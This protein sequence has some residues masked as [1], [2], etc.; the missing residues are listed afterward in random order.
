MGLS[1]LLSGPCAPIVTLKTSKGLSSSYHSHPCRYSTP[2]TNRRPEMVKKPELPKD[3]AKTCYLRIS[4]QP[5]SNNERILLFFWSSKARNVITRVRLGRFWF[6]RFR[7]F[8]KAQN[9]TC[10]Q[11]DSSV[12]SIEEPWLFTRQ[13]LAFMAQAMSTMKFQENSI[14]EY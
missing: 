6:C 13:V 12:P 2:A 14:A 8:E 11:V 9:A 10:G 1:S 4:R 3:A 7:N 5:N